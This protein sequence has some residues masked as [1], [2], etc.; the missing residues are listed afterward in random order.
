MPRICLAAVGIYFGTTDQKPA[1]N[2]TGFAATKFRNAPVVNVPDQASLEEI[3][4]EV[5]ALAANGGIPGCD[6]FNL[7]TNAFGFIRSVEANYT[8]RPSRRRRAGYYR[9][10]DHSEV[11]GKAPINPKLAWQSYLYAPTQDGI[12][13]KEADGV[14]RNARMPIEKLEDNDLIIL[15]CVL[16]ATAPLEFFPDPDLSLRPSGRV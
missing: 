2:A 9:L 5:S 11:E 16:I 1:P 4:Y 13:Q 8:Q 3:A 14:T 7:D 15:R 12:L 6:Y 10:G